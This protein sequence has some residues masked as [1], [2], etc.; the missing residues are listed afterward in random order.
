MQ[1]VVTKHWFK[2]VGLHTCFLQSLGEGRIFQAEQESYMS[3]SGC[4]EQSQGIKL[5]RTL[6]PSPKS[7]LHSCGNQQKEAPYLTHFCLLYI[8]LIQ[9]SPN[10]GVR[11]NGS[12]GVAG[13]ASAYLRVPAC[14]S[15]SAGLHVISILYRLGHLPAGITALANQNPALSSWFSPKLILFSASWF[16]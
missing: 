14:L 12:G 4:S 5:K 1:V 9:F 2:R 7:I 3:P 13:D 15:P 10:T 11:Q 16:I 6:F 8:F